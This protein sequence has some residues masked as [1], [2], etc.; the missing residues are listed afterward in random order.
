MPDESFSLKAT[1]PFCYEFLPANRARVFPLPKHLRRQ[2]LLAIYLR[3]HPIAVLF[4]DNS[5]PIQLPVL[6]PV[7][8][9]MHS[10]AG[11]IL[12]RH[13]DKISG[14]STRHGMFIRK[15]GRVLFPANRSPLLPVL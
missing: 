13:A 12:T 7:K 14:E 11:N 4:L 10:R 9:R 3:E 1:G 8:V 15:D 5:L 6:K 2:L